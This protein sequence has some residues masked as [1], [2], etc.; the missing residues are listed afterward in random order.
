MTQEVA[1]ILQQTRVQ[2]QVELVVKGPVTVTQEEAAQGPWVMQLT[3]VRH[4]QVELEAKVPAPE[5]KEEFWN[6][7]KVKQ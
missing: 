2:L 7:P 4:Q 5:T 3:R 6:V 1:A